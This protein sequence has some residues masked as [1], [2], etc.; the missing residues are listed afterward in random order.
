MTSDCERL[1]EGRYICIANAHLLI[2]VQALPFQ[3]NFSDAIGIKDKLL[4]IN[5]RDTKPFNDDI[6]S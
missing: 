2:G 3:S 5:I 6:D 1:G 4:E